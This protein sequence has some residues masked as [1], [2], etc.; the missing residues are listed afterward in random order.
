MSLLDLLLP[1]AGKRGVF[2][3]VFFIA[4]LFIFPAAS[5]RAAP[6]KVVAMGDSTTAGTPFFRSPAEVPPDG[7]GN[8]EAQ[9]SFWLKKSFPDWEILNR[10]VNGERT[11]QM[12][13][14]FQSDVLD[15][16]PGLVI[17]LGGVNDLY[18]GEEPAAIIRNLKAMYALARQNGIRVMA[19]TV[20]PYDEMTPR[21]FARMR[22]VNEWIRANAAAEKFLF[23]DTYRA[24][25]DPSRPGK[26]S[27][28]PEGLHPD[29]P[30]YRR[31]GE[32]VAEALKIDIEKD[33]L[34]ADT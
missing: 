15:H 10:G 18:Q 34:R 7:R 32:A 28:S 6:L 9:Y 19:C 33:V 13:E 14:R 4:L 26:L 5:L 25:E 20:L 16:K 8:P 22:E 27:G 23:C 1:G 17:I 12:L 21:V 30:A 29:L 24:V 31:M 11:D 3:S 2:S